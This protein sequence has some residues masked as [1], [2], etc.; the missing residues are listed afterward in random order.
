MKNSNTTTTA[1]C[2]TCINFGNIGSGPECLDLISFRLPGQTKFRAAQAHDHCPDYAPREV[3]LMSHPDGDFSIT[4][5]RVQDDFS[6][7]AVMRV[8][9]ECG[10]TMA[11][12][13][14]SIGLI[15]LGVALVQQGKN[16]V[17]ESITQ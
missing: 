9:D 17:A 8:T 6:D 16:M 4:M 7:Y 13:L 11:L 14:G 1:T 10:A 12:K 3:Q 15:E 2:A 5:E